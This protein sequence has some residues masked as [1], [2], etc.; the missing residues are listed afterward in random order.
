MAEIDC[1]DYYKVVEHLKPICLMHLKEVFEGIIR[2]VGENICLADFNLQYI[3][4]QKTAED[5]EWIYQELGENAKIFIDKDTLWQKAK[6]K[7]FAGT[8]VAYGV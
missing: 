6:E 3:R 2:H 8:L 5:L 1:L 7:T 4:A